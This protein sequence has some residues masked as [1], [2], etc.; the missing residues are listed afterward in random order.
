MSEKKETSTTIKK[1]KVYGALNRLLAEVNTKY[2]YL[3]GEMYDLDKE[4]CT[5]PSQMY[6]DLHAD[7]GGSFCWPVEGL[8]DK[9]L[10]KEGLALLRALIEDY[11]NEQSL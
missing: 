11:E 5:L 8:I 4:D 1:V 3:K 9:K 6:L 2:P 7:C 10:E